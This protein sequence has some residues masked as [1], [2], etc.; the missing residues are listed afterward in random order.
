MH[1][2]CNKKP[3]ISQIESKMECT[4]QQHFS[5]IYINANVALVLRS[6]TIT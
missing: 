1:K 2:I 6:K 4:M 3:K 5:I